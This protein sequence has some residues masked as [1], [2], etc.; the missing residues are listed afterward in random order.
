MAIACTILPHTT[1]LKSVNFQ[2]YLFIY[3][4]KSGSLVMDGGHMKP[5]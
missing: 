2:L 3:F 5:I 1:F 4:L